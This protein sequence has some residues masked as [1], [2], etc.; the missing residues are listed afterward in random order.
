M[1]STDK[2]IETV[3]AFYFGILCIVTSIV[4]SLLVI[5]SENK[6]LTNKYLKLQKRLYEV[7]FDLPDADY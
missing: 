4:G 3:S 7:K 2:S 6:F 5:F 1:Q